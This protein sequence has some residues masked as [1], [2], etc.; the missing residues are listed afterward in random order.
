MDPRLSVSVIMPA[1]NEEKSIS[2]S[3]DN[4]LA[5]F[6]AFNIEGEVIVVNDGSTDKTPQLVKDK[7]AGDKRINMVTHNSP[8]GIGASFWDGVDAAK[9]SI[10]TMLPGDNENDPRETLC[11]TSLLQ[12]VDIVIP[13][14]FNKNVRSFFRNILS[15]LYVWIVNVSFATSFNY[16]NS[17]VIY[18]KSILKQLKHR[19]SSFFYQTDILIRTVKNGYLFSEVPY[20]LGLRGGGSSKAVTFSSFLKVAK[21]YLRLFGDIYFTKLAQRKKIEFTADSASKKRYE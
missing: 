11:Y 17:T 10:V 12:H 19:E 3:I 15:C 6:D 1:L 9:G 4:T 21:G 5:A 8:E 7:M 13:F 20:R 2:L 14:A 16:T 18:R